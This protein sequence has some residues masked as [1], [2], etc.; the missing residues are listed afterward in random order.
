[1]SMLKSEIKKTTLHRRDVEAVTKHLPNLDLY[2]YQGALV[3]SNRGILHIHDAF[4]VNNESALIQKYKPLLLL[5]GSGK[6]N[7]ESTQIPLDNVTLMTTNL[8][9]MA[10]LEKYLTSVK[11][12]DRIEKIPI[13]YL[14]DVNAEIDLLKRDIHGYKRDYDIDPNFFKIAAYFSVMSRLCPPKEPKDEWV[15]NKGIFYENLTPDQKM[16]IYASKT[17]NIEQLLY[18]LPYWHPFCTEARHLGIDL[19]KPDTY[20]DKI[21]QHPDAVDLK[22]CGLFKDKELGYIDEDLKDHLRREHYPKEGNKGISTRQMQNILRDVIL[23]SD[24]RKIT[25]SLFLDQLKGILEESSYINSWITITKELASEDHDYFEIEKLINTLECLYWAHLNKELTISITDRDPKQIEYDLR[26]YLQHVLLHHAKSMTKLKKVLIEQF[27]YVDSNGGG[28][29]TEPN[30]EY[31]E[32]I[33]SILHNK[34]INSTEEFRKGISQ[35]LLDGIHDKDI[36]LKS[37]GD[38]INSSDDN[39]IQMFIKEHKKLL[40]NART[41][42]SLNTDKLKDAFFHKQNNPEE[43]GKCSAK[44]KQMCEK[45]INNM[46]MNFGYSN[47]TALEAILYGFRHD[48]IKL[49]KIIK[50]EEKDA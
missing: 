40:S 5:L 45:V 43:Y 3:S 30:Y 44:I 2:Q 32:S 21:Q 48:I 13:N 24:N 23:K 28:K 47:D 50:R 8:E 6:I 11:L 14:I 29:V 19:K 17:N 4:D 46:K 9:E 10:N 7:V 26:K 41:N 39:I 20:K 18:N 31:M 37:T 36:M 49:S 27:S 33:E 16:F 22:D 35:R 15:A 25:V 12:L 1:M 38:I 42:D 34:Y